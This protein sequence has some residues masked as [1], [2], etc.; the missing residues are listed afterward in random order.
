MSSLEVKDLSFSYSKNSQPLFKGVNFSI[1]S[2]ERV[3]LCAPSGFGKSTLCKILAGYLR[4]S[5]GKVLLNGKEFGARNNKPNPVQLVWQHPEQVMDPYLRI[6]RSLQEVGNIDSEV[7]DALGIRKEWL[8]RFPHEL[9]GGELQRCC[10]ARTLSLNPK[11]I[12][13]DEISTMLD[14]VTQVQ[15]WTFLLDYIQQNSIGMLLVT[16]SDS[17]RM[18]LATRTINLADFS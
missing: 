13:A 8:N 16:H 17:L 2:S 12:I 10:L 4:L 11:F 9:S 1:D 7:L 3:A 5:A 18:R 15:I 14:A 6:S